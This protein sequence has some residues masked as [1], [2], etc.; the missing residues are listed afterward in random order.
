MRALLLT[1]VLAGGGLLGAS[2]LGPLEPDVG[3]LVNP[4]CSDEDSDP[5]T[6]VSFSQ[7]LMPLFMR[8]VGGCPACHL[9]GGET[10]VGITVGGLDL[11][12]Y[13]TL[14][15]GGVQSQGDIVLPGQPC[16]SVLYEKLS[17]GPPF[18]SRMPLNGPPFFTEAELMIVHDWIAEG[19]LEN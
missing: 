11:S 19:A 8:D 12:T 18:G 10:P 3:P 13:E 7:D 5:D 6:D 4:F 17:A 9:P 14:F 2:C 15:Q 1:L 16:D